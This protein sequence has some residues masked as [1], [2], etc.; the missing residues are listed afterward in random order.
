M[1]HVASEGAVTTVTLD[2][3]ERRN[4][5]DHAT[6]VELRQILARAAEQRVRALV[7][8]GAGGTFC[9]GAD[10]TGVEDHGFADELR[11][12]LTGLTE[13]PAAT[14]ASVQGAALGAGC[15]LAMA[16]DLRV[17]TASAYFGIPANRLGLMVDA[18][19]VQ[20]VAQLVGGSVARAMLLAAQT[21]S[22]DEAATIGLLN[23]T[24]DLE[25]AK[26]WARSIAELAPLSV[27]GHKLA[28]ERL[29]PAGVADDVVSEVMRAV[30]SSSDAQEGR[31]A[32]LEKRTARFLGR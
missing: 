8:A 27:A 28:L 9:A 3:P 30:W 25:E 10:L 6:L 16:C 5:V 21:V 15:Q 17:G 20:R 11:A 2:R 32:F 19:T 13:L 7:L 22:A 14:I 31:A 18:W 23:R 12:V 26:A 1:I 29:Q 24:G 4:A